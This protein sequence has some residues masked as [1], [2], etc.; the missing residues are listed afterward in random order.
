MT[1]WEV[2][3]EKYCPECGNII[4]SDAVQCIECGAGQP[5]VTPSGPDEPFVCEECHEPVREEARR[6]PH[7]GYNAAEEYMNEYRKW[8]RF[9]GILALL[10]VGLPLVPL[11]AWQAYYYKKKADAATVALSH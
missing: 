3:E 2:T 8:R 5:D 9:S 11:T 10:L 4:P 1:A 7:C 6:C